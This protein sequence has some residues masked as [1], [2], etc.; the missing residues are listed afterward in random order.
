MGWLWTQIS[1]AASAA[2]G[3]A[4]VA[5][6]ALP[7]AGGTMTNKLVLDAAAATVLA[8]V[9]AVTHSVHVGEGDM[10]V[11]AGTRSGLFELEFIAA[12]ELGGAAAFRWRR[13]GGA[14]QDNAAAGYPTAADVVLTYDT[15]V[16]SGQHVQFSAGPGGGGVNDFQIG[17]TYEFIVELGVVSNHQAVQATIP[18]VTPQG[19]YDDI[20]ITSDRFV[21]GSLFDSDNRLL[22]AAAGAYSTGEPYVIQRTPAAGKLTL[23]VLNDGLAAV[24]GNALCTL[25]ALT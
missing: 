24:N 11:A 19:D 8:T 3:A 23:R 5:A 2:A 15:T 18:L 10:A 1:N 13:D 16:P 20:E 17:D 12:G 25:K 7:K 9:Y 6:A 4:G 22:H 14:W 21:V